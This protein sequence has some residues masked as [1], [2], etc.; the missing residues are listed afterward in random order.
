M[1]KMILVVVDAHSKWIEAYTTSGSTSAI[2]ISKL[3]WIF[4]SHGI[5]DVIVSDN[6]TGFVSEEFESF[7]R[8]NGIKH[9]TSAPHHPASNGLAE[10]DVG[11]LK[12][13]VQHLQGD[14]DTR[15]AH[16]LF[17]YR[18]TPHTTTGISPAE[19]L[20][21]RKLKTRLCRITP[22]VT[23]KAVAKQTI[24][25]ELHDRRTRVRGYQPGDLVYVLTYRGNATSW[26]PGTV[27][28]Q[29][30]PV[31][32]T[33]RLEEGHIVRRHVDQLQG[34]VSSHQVIAVRHLRH[35]W[36]RHTRLM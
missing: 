26:A 25:K 5:P 17:D 8:H 30:G 1:N 14:L 7:C 35:K 3:R 16:F 29:T 31:S 34:R 28:R 2:T 9:L 19:L 18:I 20:V 22:D 21:G 6:A 33:V 27:T 13:G 32:Y 11:I 36:R 24:Q 23:S 10:R 12:G 15:I 4:S